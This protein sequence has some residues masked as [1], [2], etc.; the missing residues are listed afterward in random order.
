MDRRRVV[1]SWLSGSRAA[2]GQAGADSG[3]PGDIGLPLDVGRPGERLGLPP[4]GPGSVAPFAL[5]LLAVGLDWGACLLVVRL[6]L[7]GVTYGSAPYGAAT[8]LVF[9]AEV[10][11]LTWLGG[12]SFGHRLARLAVVRVDRRPVGLQR[13]L[14]RTALLS[15]AVPPLVWD[16]DGR[17][18]HDKA[19]GTV[20]VRRP[21]G[22]ASRPPS[23]MEGLDEP[24]PR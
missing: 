17:G 6:L 20:V 1:G 9:A 19:A 11:V 5:R 22:A 2:A 12:A 14:L 8:L 4:A 15:L 16:R 7:P 23:S 24:A 18:L 21:T 10:F 3:Q 13:A